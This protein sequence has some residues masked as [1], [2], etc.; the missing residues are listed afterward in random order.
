MRKTY[1]Q[2]ERNEALKLAEE[3][4]VTSAGQRLGINHNTIFNWRSRVAIKEEKRA[5]EPQLSNEEWRAENKRLKKELAEKQE[6]VEI[7][8]AALGFFAKSRKK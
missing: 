4:G 1:N 7:M 8:Q 2:E 6:E 5:S 3:I